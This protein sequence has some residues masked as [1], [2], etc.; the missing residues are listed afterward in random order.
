LESRSKQVFGPS[1]GESRISH[2]PTHKNQ[3]D[4]PQNTTKKKNPKKK[5]KKIRKGTQKR[6]QEIA[7]HRAIGSTRGFGGAQLFDKD[8]ANAVLN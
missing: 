4:K 7:R 5:K 1:M 6:R 8:K 2:T 3:T